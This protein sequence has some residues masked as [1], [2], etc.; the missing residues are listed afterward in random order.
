MGGCKRRFKLNWLNEMP[1]LVY[2]P[3]LD[4]AFCLPCTIFV[5]DRDKYGLLVNKPFRAWHRKSDKLVPHFTMHYH[6]QSVQASE[7]FIKSIEQPQSTVTVMHDTIKLKNIKH[8]RDIIKAVANVVL[9]CGRQCIGLKGKE[10]FLNLPGNPGNFLALM[11]LLGKYNNDI[12]MHIEHPSLKNATYLTPRIQNELIVI[13][14]VHII[15]RKLVDEI[16]KAKLFT[17]L[18]DEVSS[19]HVEQMPLCIRFVDD[20]SA[21]R[22]EFLEFCQLKSLYIAHAIKQALLCH[23]LSLLNLRGQGYDG[24]SNMSSER[25]GV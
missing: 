16:K 24:A 4:G 19:H 17:V 25:C 1:G 12:K 8:N 15:Q 3:L 14:G 21:I 7:T 23:D 9:Y 10:E 18:V 2:S 11:R 6:Y 22:E 5:T 13:M 20:S